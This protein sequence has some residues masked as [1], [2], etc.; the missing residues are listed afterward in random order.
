MS[1]G[2]CVELAGQGLSSPA[3]AQGAPSCEHTLATHLQ[4]WPV[5]LV[6]GQAGVGLGPWLSDQ[7]ASASSLA[8]T[9]L[10]DYW[11]WVGWG[12]G[13]GQDRCTRG[14]ILLFSISLHC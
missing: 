4:A 10:A 13:W 1:S 5:L 11:E 8:L 2:L 7:L 6:V 12:C 3:V 14:P 9:R